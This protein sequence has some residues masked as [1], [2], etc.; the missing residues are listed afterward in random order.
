MLS[1]K[2]NPCNCIERF[3][4]FV[5]LSGF[6]FTSMIPTEI[7]VEYEAHPSIQPS[8]E[9]HL[10]RDPLAT[11]IDTLTKFFAYELKK[12]VH[13]THAMGKL[14]CWWAILPSFL[15]AVTHQLDVVPT[16]AYSIIALWWL[17]MVGVFLLKSVA[18][19]V[20]IIHIL[21]SNEA[22]IHIKVIV[23]GAVVVMQ[24]MAYM[25]LAYE[26]IVRR[27]SRKFQ[28]KLNEV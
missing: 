14:Q 27:R 13:V 7:F 22:I 18:E 12:T 8:D 28:S 20:T 24:A 10:Y 6:L 19:L 4:L 17:S 11:T 23:F 1:S 21:I 26:L 3:V 5:V 16:E 2:L 15:L 25:N 9:Q